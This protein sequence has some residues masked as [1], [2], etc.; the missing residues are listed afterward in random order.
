MSV[1]VKENGNLT[2]V[3]G[4]YIP[5]QFPHDDTKADQTSI[6]NVENGTTASQA[7]SVGDF[8]Y[9]NGDFCVVTQAIASESPLTENT[10]YTTKKIS[11]AIRTLELILI[12][13]S[14][15]NNADLNTYQT[16]GVYISASSTVT[17]TLSN[18]PF[19]GSG[20]RLEVKRIASAS[21]RVCQVI[22]PN[23][24]QGGHFIRLKTTATTW[25]SWK[26]IIWND[27]S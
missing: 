2:K 12:P 11:D 7:Y 10:N 27:I 4:L 22:Y 5:S 18:C 8:F 1:N 21:G 19:T 9:R 25:Y 13:Q 23:S 3:G 20:F 16:E 24:S 15:P 26:K 17:A 6:A 14:I